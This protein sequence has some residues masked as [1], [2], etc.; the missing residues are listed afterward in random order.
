MKKQLLRDLKKIGIPSSLVLVGWCWFM[1]ED[2]LDIL[3]YL[4]IVWI[5]IVIFSISYF[6]GAYYIDASE[7]D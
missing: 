3:T 6:I 2:F 1:D 4:L 5:C 7:D